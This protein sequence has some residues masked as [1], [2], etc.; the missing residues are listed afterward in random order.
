V[1]F[2]FFFR[3]LVSLFFATFRLSL[4]SFGGA[5]VARVPADKIVDDQAWQY[6]DGNDWTS[7]RARAA[8]IIKPGVGEGSLA[9]NAGLQ[10]W[11][12]TTL[13]ELSETIEL[14]LADRPQGPWS[15]PIALVVL[16]NGY[17]QAYGAFMTPSW[18]STD[19]LSFYFVMSQFGPYNTY[20]MHARLERR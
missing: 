8:E 4:A 5:R 2:F 17:P 7:D 16:A 20:V 19:G 15:D 10:K 18:I 6:F 9:W 11:M 1:S 13:D 3:V 14:R 12:F